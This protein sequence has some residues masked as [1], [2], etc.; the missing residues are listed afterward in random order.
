M[1]QLNNKSDDNKKCNNVN[2]SIYKEAKLIMS[3]V[4]DGRG[5]TLENNNP[6][7]SLSRYTTTQFNC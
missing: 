3:W 7:Y 4:S 6:E 5:I 1:H 2:N